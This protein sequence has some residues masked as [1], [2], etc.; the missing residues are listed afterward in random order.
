MIDQFEDLMGIVV[1]TGYAPLDKK[2]NS[3]ICYKGGGGGSTTTESGVPEEFR[4]YVERGLADAE[5]ARQEGRLSYVAPMESEQMQSLEMQKDLATGQLQD[6]AQQS[7]AAR[8]VLGQASRGEGI[9]GTQGYQMVADDMSDRLQTLGDQARGQ[10]Q[11]SSALGGTLGSARQQAMTE[12]AVMDTMFNEVSKELAA[13]RQGRSGA[14]Q[15]VIASGQDVAGQAGLGAAALERVGATKQTQAQRVGDA[16]YQGL[17]R[18][19]GLLGSPA[20]GQETKTT[21]SSGGK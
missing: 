2:L 16:D 18:F 12:K 17:Q 20:V 7:T 1:E 13:Q 8:D 21:Q 4:P 10:A 11:T 5:T 6:I 9:F 15:G 14:A 3:H 19:F